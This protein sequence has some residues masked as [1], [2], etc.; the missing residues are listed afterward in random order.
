MKD[1]ITFADLL[2]NI[3][4]R[5]MGTSLSNYLKGSQI[6]N[7][8]VKVPLRLIME[9]NTEANPDY[10]IQGELINLLAQ[11]S[12]ANMN[13]MDFF[14]LNE[15]DQLIAEDLEKL[16]ADLPEKDDKTKELARE[17][18]IFAIRNFTMRNIINR[19]TTTKR[20]KGRHTCYLT[21]YSLEGFDEKGKELKMPVILIPIDIK[22]DHFNDD[23]YII[24]L[25]KSG[26][27][28]VNPVIFRLYGDFEDHDSKEP[29]ANPYTIDR[30]IWIDNYFNDNRLGDAGKDR[31]IGGDKGSGLLGELR[32]VFI[33]SKFY[34]K[35]KFVLEEKCTIGIYDFKTHIIH[36][37]YVK[38]QEHFEKSHNIGV[39]TGK[40]S[41]MNITAEFNYPREDFSIYP[42]DATQSYA[43]SLVRSG[44]DV[45]LQGPPGTG[46]SQTIVNL[47]AQFMAD[48][49]R[50]LFVTE[51]VE[52]INVVYD[53]LKSDGDKDI[54]LNNFCLK[55]TDDTK[56]FMTPRRLI[57]QLKKA[58]DSMNSASYKT[59]QYY[60][61]LE[62]ISDGIID[63]YYKMNEN[64]ILNRLYGKLLSVYN[65]NSDVNEIA[66]DITDY[67]YNPK[68]P[69]IP[70]KITDTIE[71]L[72]NNYPLSDKAFAKRCVDFSGI[73]N[74][75]KLIENAYPPSELFYNLSTF[76][77]MLYDLNK[78]YFKGT[79]F[80]ELSFSDF[81]SFIEEIAPHLEDTIILLDRKGLLFDLLNLD[82]DSLSR[83]VNSLN[84]LEKHIGDVSERYRIEEKYRKEYSIPDSVNEYDV[85]Q[86]FGLINDIKKYTLS[87]S[88][89]R[90]QTEIKSYKRA[91]SNFRDLLENTR[92][93]GEIIT[94]FTAGQIYSSGSFNEIIGMCEILSIIT[95]SGIKDYLPEK[96]LKLDAR[97]IDKYSRSLKRIEEVN[98]IKKD[99]LYKFLESSEFALPEDLSISE[100]NKKIEKIK[101]IIYEVREEIEEIEDKT[102]KKILTKVFNLKSTRRKLIE[103]NLKKKYA[104][105][106]FKS[107]KDIIE[108]IEKINT[109]NNE[110]RV[111]LTESERE[112]LTLLDI[113]HVIRLEKALSEMRNI[114]KTY[115]NINYRIDLNKIISSPD[116]V[117]ELL[118]LQ[119]GLRNPYDALRG[120]I[121]YSDEESFDVTER[122][123]KDIESIIL[124]LE[125]YFGDS[126]IL[127]DIDIHNLKRYAENR[128]SLD[129]RITN[130]ENRMKELYGDK[131]YHIALSDT[132][133]VKDAIIN[134]QKIIYSKSYISNKETTIK[135]IHDFLGMIHL[136]DQLIIDSKKVIDLYKTIQPFL[137]DSGKF[138]STT[139]LSSMPS[140]FSKIVGNKTSKAPTIKKLKNSF[141]YYVSIEEEINSL[142]VRNFSSIIYSGIIKSRFD[143]AETL[144]NGITKYILKKEIE[145]YERTK[146]LSRN[147]HADI[148]KFIKYEEKRIKHNRQAIP[149][150]LRQYLRDSLKRD[151]D[152]TELVNNLDTKLTFS[153]KHTELRSAFDEAYT[154]AMVLT[155]CW[156]MTPNIVSLL[157]KDPSLTNPDYKGK[158]LNEK[159]MFDVVVFDEAS[160]IRIEDAVP[161]LARAKH[162]IVIG[163]DKQLPPSRRFERGE[164]N[165][166]S[167]MHEIQNVIPI[168][169]LWHYR[170][171]SEELIHFSNKHFYN[172]NLIFY[173]STNKN[174]EY[175]LHLVKVDGKWDERKNKQEADIA[176]NMFNKHLSENKNESIGI[177]TINDEQ[178]KYIINKLGNSYMKVCGGHES[179][180]KN[181][182]NVQGDERDVIILSVSY[183]GD[184]KSFGEISISEEGRKRLNVAITRAKKRMYVLASPKLLNINLDETQEGHFLVEFLKYCDKIT[185]EK[186]NSTELQFKKSNDKTQILK[187]E[188]ANKLSKTGTDTEID[189]G[190]RN[191]EIH[192]V[193]KKGKNY[194]AIMTDHD[195][196]RLLIPD[197]EI[198]DRYS[199]RDREMTIRHILTERG[200]KYH[201]LTCQDAVRKNISRV[202]K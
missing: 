141:N 142:G 195:N 97:T 83:M 198:D 173:P 27:I 28:A 157:M 182:E 200:W 136:K 1:S 118:K 20:E 119:A 65:E 130:D 11:D 21:F 19:Y 13:I 102:V 58:N 104:K 199:I 172:E 126:G 149:Y 60:E 9:Y 109:Y 49:K 160:Q 98:D 144:L 179:F 55:I 61:A 178:K 120:I 185:K 42:S 166:R 121:S 15:S 181:I 51:K 135:L 140:S 31:L 174:E 189:Y 35:N 161:S 5:S 71:S 138:A 114:L 39:I 188:I 184:T 150:K 180:V 24:T 57:D 143:S 40:E 108:G 82:T 2:D 191:K 146:N 125:R 95:N 86:A 64:D 190:E 77:D 18:K 80:K 53:R 156:M 113:P 116:R 92:K 155:P 187:R 124:K 32:R 148:E 122:K 196:G 110:I 112:K 4:Q 87:F 176:V 167:L 66:V 132:Q 101:S 45:F 158:F 37:D 94:S 8:K 103:M 26:D 85:K 183:T 43:V 50:I 23:E 84:D 30:D 107:I 33:K 123:V 63:Y 115:S 152:L 159:D 105:K 10:D 163:D 151:A 170:S 145:R 68:S 16:D 171:L 129:E 22:R 177:V 3:G 134:I 93:I 201:R 25:E 70:V 75:K 38:N 52:A 147:I 117:K 36:S 202:I 79:D 175:G 131:I 59:F 106:S 139:K 96:D 48:G 194:H 168:K 41:S 67:E 29:I 76:R 111:L 62:E 169:L 54:G 153:N 72:F 91:I 128:Y 154:A 162:F 100:I 192:V 12:R 69:T 46:K 81:I 89:E 7:K 197:D 99:I 56:K 6:K 186:D 88:E 34:K 193:Y 14:S 165:M 47:I 133:G 17:E 73:I 90:I 127:Q 74:V 44:G 78:D 137:C 164:K